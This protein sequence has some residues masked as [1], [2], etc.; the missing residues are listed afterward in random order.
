MEALSKASYDDKR[1]KLN[2]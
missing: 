1:K 2:N